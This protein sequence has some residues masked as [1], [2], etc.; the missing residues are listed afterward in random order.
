MYIS[1]QPFT[2]ESQRFDKRCWTKGRSVYCNP[3][4]YSSKRVKL[5]DWTPRNHLK[6]PKI[7]MIVR[8]FTISKGKD[9]LPVPSFCRGK[10]AVELRECKAPHLSKGSFLNHKHLYG[11]IPV[12]IMHNCEQ[13]CLRH[14]DYYMQ[15]EWM[16]YQDAH[17]LNPLVVR[18][19]DVL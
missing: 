2:G 18:V 8:N 17:I 7:N 6:P 15:W 14:W 4:I 19:V 1:I 11:D 10:L 12:G 16:R 5:T 3:G 13:T 9:C